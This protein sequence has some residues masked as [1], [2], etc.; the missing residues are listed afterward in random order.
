MVWLY[1]AVG[2]GPLLSG[3]AALLGEWNRRHIKRLAS[4]VNGQTHLLVTTTHALG[5]TEGVA[6]A[7]SAAFER[8]DVKG[9]P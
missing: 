5:V 3:V 4:E 8:G 6:Q 7:Q 9:T 1:I 2:L